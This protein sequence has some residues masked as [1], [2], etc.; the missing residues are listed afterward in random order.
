MSRRKAE[1]VLKLIDKASR[2]ARRF[3]AVQKRMGRATELANRVSGRSA[4][5]AKRATDLYTRAVGR[6]DR[7]QDALR[8]GVRRTNQV[9]ATQTARLRSSGAM[10]RSGIAGFGKA[11]VVAGGLWTAYSGSAVAAASAIIGPAAQFEKF[12]IQLATLEGSS[13]KGRQAMEWIEDFATRTPLELHQVVEAYQQMRTFGLDPTNGSL[14]ALVDSMAASG[15]GIDHLQGLTLALGKAWT[16]GKLQG[17]EIMMLL[18]RG[19]PVWDMLAEKTGKNVQQLQELASKGKLGRNEI[20]LLIDA[21]AAK[22]AGASENISKSWDGI[23]SNLMDWWTKFRRMI[24]DSGVFDWMKDKLR[25]FLDYLNTLSETGDLQRYADTIA[26]YILTGLEALWAMGHG[27]MDFWQSFYP[28]L[29]SA[30]DALGGWRN[31]ALAVLAIPLRGFIIGAAVGLFQFTRG[32]IL[33]SRALAS[34]GLLS[35]ASGAMRLSGAFLSIL[36]PLK[37]VR[38]AFVAIRVAIISTGI[39][40]LV[41]GL[42]MAGTWIYNNWSGLVAFFKGFG[43]SFMASLGPARPMVQG[44]V[45]AAST[46]WAWMTKLIGPIDANAETWTK[47]G[48]MVGSA[49]GRVV[50]YIMNLPVHLSGLAGSLVDYFANINLYDAGVA[51][52]QSLWDGAASLLGAMVDAISAKLSGI[53]PDWMKSAWDWVQS[54]AQP[55]H[56][57]ASR[58]ASRDVQRSAAVTANAARAAAISSAVAAGGAVA[59]EAPADGTRYLTQRAAGNTTISAPVTFEITGN[60]DRQVMPDLEDLAERA[61]EKVAEQI[62]EERRWGHD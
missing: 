35:A 27:A 31:L 16:K 43:E 26:K 5:A 50:S 59:S 20:Q 28:V 32:A 41:V 40:A 29:Q 21:M 34:I 2:P 62:R 7:A 36:N 3:M 13:E 23:I 46:L 6:L 17:E 19:V 51:I 39:G 25:G 1:M 55:A 4:A 18:E 58:A 15:K 33:A 47:W 52:M 30:A 22:N 49:V 11:A 56:G 57:S 38:A 54:D 45:D 48:Q 37:L 9:I 53:V 42:A 61:A 60:V 12:Q 24:A 14:N 8:A 10:M 44:I